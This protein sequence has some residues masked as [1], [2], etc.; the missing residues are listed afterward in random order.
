MKHLFEIRYWGKV[1]STE[2]SDDTKESFPE[3]GP[4]DFDCFFFCHLR[5]TEIEPLVTNVELAI[6]IFSTIRLS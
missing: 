4:L 3:S 2:Y 1:I 5:I 6:P